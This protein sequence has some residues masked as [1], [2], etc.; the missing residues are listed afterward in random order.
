MLSKD[1]ILKRTGNGLEVFRHYIPG[2]WRVGRNFHNPLYD[3]R[4]ASCN[5]YFD[6]RNGFYRLKDFGNDD[7]SG[8]CFDIVGKINS[9]NC[10][11]AQDFVEILKI[12]NH[13][14]Y[15][16]LDDGDY[17]FTSFVCTP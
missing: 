14:L 6:R 12:I 10:V 13:D 2:Q 5:I 3:D 4:K 15:L 11:N 1:E 9:L 17:S 8:D 7:F 16:G